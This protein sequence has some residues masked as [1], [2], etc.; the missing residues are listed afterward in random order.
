MLFW[1]AQSPFAPAHTYF[2]C[3]VLLLS[4]GYFLLLGNRGKN[5]AAL[6]V[7]SAAQI[8]SA[9]HRVRFVAPQIA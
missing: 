4:L 8:C 1:V 2:V 6:H 7:C 9:V 3:I 5:F